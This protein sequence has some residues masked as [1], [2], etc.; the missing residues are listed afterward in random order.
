MA[1]IEARRVEYMGKRAVLLAND[2]VRTLIE[3]AGGMVPEFG[4]R[5]GPAVLNAHWIPDFRDN[6]GTPFSQ[7]VHGPYWKVK[8]LHILAGDFPCS[9]SFGGGC[10]VDGV[11]LPPHGWAANDDWAIEAV[12]VDE[13]A[14]AGWTRSSLLSPAP[15]MPLKW[16]KYDFLFAG[17]AAYYSF[18]RVENSGA[19]PI[20]INLVRHN[21]IGAPM[22]AAGC[23]ISLSA[24]RFMAAPQGTEFDPTGRLAQGVEFK[25]LAAA[26]LRAGG[27]ADIREVPGMIGYSD[28][29]M[30][31]VPEK[32]ALGWSCLVNPALKLGYIAFFPGAAGLPEGEIAASF[33]ELWL[34]YG[35]RPFPPW[36][37]EE[38]GADRTFCLGTENGTSSFGNGLGYARANPKLLGRDTLVEIP[39]KGARTL[40]YGTALVSL[41]DAL[42]REGVEGMEAE[43]GN[44]VLKG[45]RAVQKVKMGADF[46]AAR[47]LVA[48][49]DR[50]A[51]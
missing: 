29:V 20:T 25:S 46:T 36:A 7:D 5:R 11:K 2:E 39:A 17:E 22:L 15:S 51:K 12:G 26:P 49:L 3:A 27:T 43:P 24:D 42:A 31:A 38:G 13:Q 30:G 6:S 35:G 1:G 32:L 18:I 16:V 28:F 10:E 40:A 44:L 8:L 45:P 4:V 9:P 37:L 33:N 41:D 21:T 50:A 19:K 47:A 23:R 48:K 34:Q 14:K